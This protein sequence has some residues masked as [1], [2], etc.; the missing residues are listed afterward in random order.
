MSYSRTQRECT[1]VRAIR[2]WLAPAAIAWGLCLSVPLD[3]S[4]AQTGSE[5]KTESASS[6]G[7]KQK[8]KA[9]KS[10][11]PKEAAPPK[12]FTPSTRVPVGVP[13]DFPADI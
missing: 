9:K 7:E 10:V 8:Q 1:P 11:A 13:I 4:D 5:G 2:K 12:S 3:R 6:P